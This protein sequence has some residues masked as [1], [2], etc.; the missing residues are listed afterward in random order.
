[1]DRLVLDQLAG[2]WMHE[3]A[4]AGGQHVRRLGQQPGDHPPF[5]VAKR[6]FAILLEYLGDR[7]AGGGLDLGVG[8]AERHAER[9]GEAPADTA[10]AD[11]RQ[12]DEGDG[13]VKG[14]Q[15]WRHDRQRLYTSGASLANFA[16]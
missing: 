6:G 7:P 10:L 14:T 5:T 13:F 16:A 3:G 4:A 11:A 2:L 1:R 15:C 8:V 9:Q 12:A